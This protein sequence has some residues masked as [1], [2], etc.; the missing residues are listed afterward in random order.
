LTSSGTK[1]S[2]YIEVQRRFP[3]DSLLKGDTRV[4]FGIM[5][6]ICEHCGFD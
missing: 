4:T 1:W 3:V 5:M 6:A 2:P